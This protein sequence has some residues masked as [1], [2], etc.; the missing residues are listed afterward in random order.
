ML[1]GYF[2]RTLGMHRVYNSA[3]MHML[4]DE[5]G[6]GYRKLIRETLEFDPEILKRYV[7][8]MNNPDEKTAVEQF[9]KG[10]KYFGVATVMA[11]MPG[12]P[13]LGHGQVEG[14]AEKYG[15]EFRRATL[16]EQPDPW[17]VERHERE[18]FPLLHRRAWF[19]EA[20]DFLLYDFVTAATGGR[21]GASSP[22]RTAR[23]RPARSSSTTSA[24]G[25][26]RARSGRVE[27]RSR[28]RGRAAASGSSARSLA[29][30]LGLPDDP[31][32][33]VAFRDA[34]TGLE[35]LR[36]CREIRERG[37]WLHL[38]AYQGHVFWEFRELHDG[39]SGQWRRLADR[40]GGRGRAVARGGARGP[41]AGAGPRAAAGAVRRGP[42][43]GRARR[44]GR[45]GRPR[46]AETAA[47]ARWL[48]AVASATGVSGE[49]RS[50]RPWRPPSR[51]GPRRPSRPS[52]SR[53]PGPT[54]RPCW[55]GWCCRRIGELA[56]G[57]DVAATSAAW[58]DELRLAPVV[59]GG[60]RA[61]GLDEGEA[62][63]AADRIRVLLALPRPS[64]IRGRGGALRDA[65]SS[66]AG[67]P[68]HRVRGGDRRQHLG[69]RRVARPATA[70]RRWS[71]GR[72]GSTRSR[73]TGRRE[74]AQAPHGASRGRGLPGR[75]PAVARRSSRRRNAAPRDPPR[76]TRRPASCPRLR[77]SCTRRSASCRTGRRSRSTRPRISSVSVSRARSSPR[78]R[79]RRWPATLR[80]IRHRL[81][82]LE[83]GRCIPGRDVPGALGQLRL[84]EPQAT[85]LWRSA[86]ASAS[87]TVS[88]VSMRLRPAPAM[89]LSTSQTR[90]CGAS[91]SIDF[92]KRMAAV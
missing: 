4:R 39:S 83:V 61:A 85:A 88:T 73:T 66:S 8:F 1:E 31:D 16:E 87:S 78:R 47:G 89:S 9:G 17:L 84:L 12:L 54:G 49:R 27:R 40:L 51:P 72:S 19:A 74:A 34:R 77:G 14:F 67:W 46:R 57:A 38:D 65:V 71:R 41:A 68:T 43:S 82:P 37:L 90:C 11:T 13:M 5:D 62:W 33:F 91:I 6:A 59:A 28:A 53:W 3:F 25:R 24:S 79:R 80:G 50:P 56:P 45:A 20:H 76:P 69:G 18:I 29:E 55:A 63:A 86:P 23:G 60:L 26:P 21:R 42:M 36:S 15:M 48:E 30:A 75:R 64:T 7:N 2:V 70:S 44:A 52:T 81:R 35:Y 92:S 22:T 58:F 32:A 10:D